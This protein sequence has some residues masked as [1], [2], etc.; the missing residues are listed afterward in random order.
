[1]SVLFFWGGGGL[2]AFLCNDST[3]RTENTALLR[4][5]TKG[6]EPQ[7][8]KEGGRGRGVGLVSP[9]V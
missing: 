1:M 8:W 6:A 4:G 5:K 7:G 3:T 9:V 2:V